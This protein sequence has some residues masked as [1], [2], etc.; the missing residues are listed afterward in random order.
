MEQTKGR[1]RASLHPP[2]AFRFIGD[3]EIDKGGY[4]L[5]TGAFDGLYYR[6][7]C[8]HNIAHFFGQEGYF[9]CHGPLAGERRHF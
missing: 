4:C 6:V 1:G 5:V 9:F 3:L 8:Q 2:I 7:V